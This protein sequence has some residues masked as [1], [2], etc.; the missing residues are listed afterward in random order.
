MLSGRAL[1]RALGKGHTHPENASPHRFTWTAALRA[2]TPS[3]SRR[4]APR[5]QAQAALPLGSTRK[6][7][8]SRAPAC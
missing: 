5:E 4:R 1:K 7:R 2:A 8:V 3:A 6:P